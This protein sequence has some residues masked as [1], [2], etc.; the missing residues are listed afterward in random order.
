MK[1]V[2]LVEDASPEE[3]NQIVNEEVK[4]QEQTPITVPSKDDEKSLSDEVRVHFKQEIYTHS[5]EQIV[6]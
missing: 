3:L 2:E 5:K 6:S 4:K 1:E